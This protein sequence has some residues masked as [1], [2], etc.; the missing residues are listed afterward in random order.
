MKISKKQLKSVATAIYNIEKEL[1]CLVFNNKNQKKCWHAYNNVR[2]PIMTAVDFR[3]RSI[4]RTNI[5]NKNK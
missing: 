1:Y 2:I 4:I 3:C 5:A